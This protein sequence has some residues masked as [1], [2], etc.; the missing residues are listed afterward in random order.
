MV[1]SDISQVRLKKKILPIFFKFCSSEL[2]HTCEVCI[3]CWSLDRLS[4]T[5]STISTPIQPSTHSGHKEYRPL[6][7]LKGDGLVRRAS[8]AGIS[9]AKI[10]SKKEE[11]TAAKPKTAEQIQ[12]NSKKG[13]MARESS[14]LGA[15]VAGSLSG[16]CSTILFQPLD[17][18][19]TRLQTQSLSA[20]NGVRRVGML[21]TF[22]SVARTDRLKGLWRGLV[23]SISRTVPGVGMYFC[24]LHWLKKTFLNEELKAHQAVL[25]GLTARTFAGI[26]LLPVTVIKTRYESGQFQYR[27][28]LHALTSIYKSEGGRGLYSGLVATVLRDAPFSGLYLMFYT[29]T[30][31]LARSGFEVERLDAVQTFGCGV[32]G[33]SLASL[34]TQPADV[35]KTRMQLYPTMYSGNMSAIISILRS[36][37]VRGMFRGAV[38]RM[39]RRT[40][41]AAMAWTV[42][43]ELMVYLHFKL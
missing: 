1:I 23:P 2:F 11:Q 42:Y 28:M 14:L 34:I 19:K 40:L 31:K 29:E 12:A 25:L 16:T 24:S 13:E 17:L 41:M 37:G 30:K 39:L 7:S 8:H 21:Y 9:T 4:S 18:V 32:V 33:G 27:S 5:R 15:F 10:I 6:W 3:S 43:E 36:D 35:V 20:A 38:P 22:Y 26:T